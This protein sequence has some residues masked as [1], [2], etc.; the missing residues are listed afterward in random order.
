LLRGLSAAAIVA[1]VA[2]AAERWSNADFPPRVRAAGAIGT[3]LGYTAPVVDYA[4]DRIFGGL[5]RE[6]LE[7]SICDEL[8]SLA[9]LDGP[10]A[11]PAGLRG[12]ARGVERV[13]VLSSDTTI[14]VG[15]VPAVYALCAKCDVVVKDRND[16]LVAAFFETLVDERP[17]F[18]T[19]AVARSW[20]GGSDADE[21]RLLGTADVVVAFGADDTLRTIRGRIRPE[22]RFVP[23]GHRASIGYVD[24]S[25]SRGRDALLARIAADV[26]L[27][28]GDG[29]MS[30]HALFVEADRPTAQA[31][32][33]DLAAA[34]E[35]VCVEFP[36]GTLDARRAASAA[37]YRN[38][39][40]FRAASG[41]G[42]VYRV[43][44]D[45]TIAFDP[46]RD[47]PPPFLPRVL[48][49]FPVNGPAAAIAYVRRHGLPIE[50]IGVEDPQA[51]AALA[52][53]EA[54]GA[55]RITRF[56]QMQ[57]PPLAGHHGG[58]ARIAH[59]VRWIDLE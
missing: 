2:A 20:I 8:G 45:A 4:L 39:S 24:G 35:R 48:P 36:A 31:F 53:A 55:V 12:Y 41:H 11:G 17:E 21:S 23:F 15:I 25:V 16:L 5:T 51:P 13:A 9:A 3:R 26:L 52:F 44:E 57:A 18:R 42:A 6:A 22:A 29:C 37:A 30:L 27:Y 19:S 7:A 14:G 50:A 54:I 10:V 56:G 58:A 32:A 1:A 46:P 28:D 34:S 47:Q 59:F 40:A 43:L 38:L 49:V 33:A